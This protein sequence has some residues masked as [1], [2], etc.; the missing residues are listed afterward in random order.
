MKVATADSRRGAGVDS[1]RG[2]G[3]DSWRGVG[4][5]SQLPVSQQGEKTRVNEQKKG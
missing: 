4:A 3:V 2:V 1:W 5:D